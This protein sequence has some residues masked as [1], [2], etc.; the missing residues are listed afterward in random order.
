M[1]IIEI[2]WWLT[3][4]LLH[5]WWGYLFISKCPDAFWNIY[6][7]FS[8]LENDC[9]ICTTKIQ[10]QFQFTQAPNHLRKPSTNVHFIC[11][12]LCMYLFYTLTR[13][14]WEVHRLTKKELCH[15]NETSHAFNS[16]FP[17]TN[18]IIFFQTNPHWISNSGLW[19]IVFCERPGNWQRKSC[20]TRT[21][22]LHTSLWL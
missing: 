14:G 20:F 18:C 9:T 7:H 11:L 19:K 5:P 15:R 21:M 17:D 12:H 1:E 13:V 2:P 8:V 4:I 16:A 3:S 10:T 6:A 22:L